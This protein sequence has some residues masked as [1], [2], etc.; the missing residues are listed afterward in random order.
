MKT[1]KIKVLALFCVL[2]FTCKKEVLRKKST[3][4]TLIYI[5]I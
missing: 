5:G 3:A 4:T 1:F 2:L